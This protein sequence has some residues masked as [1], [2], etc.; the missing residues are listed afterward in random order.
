MVTNL[1]Q[2][3]SLF[4][5]TTIITTVFGQLS[6]S[7]LSQA[8]DNDDYPFTVDPIDPD[9][10]LP[11][12]GSIFTAV[13]FSFIGFIFLILFLLLCCCLLVTVKQRFFSTTP[14]I[15]LGSPAP[16]VAVQFSQF[17]Y[18]PEVPQAHFVA[19]QQQQLQLQPPSYEAASYPRKKLVIT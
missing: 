14:G 3:L 1:H 7:N 13:M 8:A 11:D 19:Q 10:D 17:P 5:L 4:I 16:P 6:D 2:F 18:P 12:P 15:V 9:N